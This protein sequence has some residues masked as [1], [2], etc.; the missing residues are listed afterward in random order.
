[1]GMPARFLLLF[2]TGAVLAYVFLALPPAV[3]FPNPELARLIALHLPNA[4]V[5]L[6]AASMAGWHGIQYLRRRDPLS[7]VRS[8]VAAQLAAVFCFLTTATGSVFAKVQWGSYWNWDPRETSVSVLLLVYAAYF[9]LRA[10]F[11]DPEKRAAVSAVYVLFASVLTPTLGY[12]IPTF[13]I[14][15]TLHPKMAKFDL[16]YR[17]A[18]YPTALCLLAV[19]LWLQRLAVR[20]ETL[21][22]RLSAA[23]ESLG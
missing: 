7:D 5:A 23:E 9:L 10:S 13:F 6:I 17:M 8:V 16:S 18:I 14:D 1:M 2:A 20:C 21:R 12:V 11:D 22:L 15:Q 4:Y 3:G 19:M